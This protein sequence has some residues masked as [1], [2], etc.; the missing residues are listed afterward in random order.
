M[1]DAIAIW[2]SIFAFHYQNRQQN[3]KLLEMIDYLCLGMLQFVRHDRI[4]YY[5]MLN[6]I[7]LSTYEG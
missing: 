3:H 4:I 2:D 7:C 5:L 6:I 1:S